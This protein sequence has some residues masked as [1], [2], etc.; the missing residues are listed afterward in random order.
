MTFSQP[1]EDLAGLLTELRTLQ[2]SVAVLGGT[3][4][5]Q[6]EVLNQR[7]MSL[8]PGT[9]QGLGE[10]G[11]LLTDVLR[12]IDMIYDELVQLRTLRRTAGAINASLD[13]DEVLNFVL[14]EA[15][16]LI[17]A[18][19]SY[20]ALRDPQT[21]I[22]SIRAGQTVD[23]VPDADL[24]K[25]SRSIIEEVAR[26]GTPVLTSDA[27]ADDQ[28]N[29]HDSI[30]LMG[31]TSVLC[32]PLTQRGA[33][34]GVLYADSRAHKG[35]FGDKEQQLLFAFANQAAA[36][37]ENAQL[38]DNLR[39]SLTEVT[40]VKLLMDNVFVS[41]GSGVITADEQNQVTIVN[42]AARRI[43]SLPTDLPDQ[44]IGQPLDAILPL[45][46]EAFQAAIYRLRTED[47]P[48]PIAIEHRPLLVGH[49]EPSVLS[50][51]LSPLH[52][53]AWLTRGVT[54]V[55]DDLT[56]I[57]RREDQLRAVRRYLTPAMVDNI[58]SID[59][60]GLGGERR[61]ITILFVDVRDFALFP[62]TVQ[63]GE[64][65]QRLNQYLTVAVEAISA[66]EGIIDKYMAN[67]V[68]ALFNTQLNPSPDHAR[69]AVQA[70][71]D[72]ANHYVR[73]F[74]PD[75][76]EAPDARYYRI[77]IHTGI[78][79]LGNTGSATRRDFTAIGD[80]VNLAHRLLENAGP[81]QILISHETFD[82]LNTV[83]ASDDSP[84]AAFEIAAFG[85]LQV[86]NRQQAVSVY[87]VMPGC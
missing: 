19:R 61:E 68:M 67:E 25:L 14:G 76:G 77:G 82:Q 24:A 46:A 7:G 86:R 53:A 84:A 85:E 87:S 71:C 42:E 47:A 50:L 44:V 40:A 57:R 70:A 5:K 32:V 62:E 49:A 80:S 16:R 8:P 20:L 23:D 41:I 83:P 66:Q 3:L 65:M 64:L 15:L 33:V 55:V 51:T 75:L 81:G 60:L 38:F 9:L 17:H 37:I 69:R 29:I 2:D 27:Q 74:Y 10:I 72:L 18:E 12:Q 31:L 43:L 36:A 48:E 45:D 79:T 73:T 58:H 22:L 63:A 4:R 1:T 52:N 39:H 30:V 11:D 78:A 13:L 34:T 28:W 59:Q 21:G 35:I 54:V 6:R 56:E 26:T